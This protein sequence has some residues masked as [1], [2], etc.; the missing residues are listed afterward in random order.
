M[1][2]NQVI[3][4]INC[5]ADVI[6]AHLTDPK[7][8]ANFDSIVDK[9][10][11]LSQTPAA[12]GS[13]FTMDI[14]DGEH[15]TPVTFRVTRFDPHRFFAYESVSGTE[16]SIVVRYFLTTEGEKTELTFNQQID[17]GNAIDSA[18]AEAIRQETQQRIERDF[19]K[20]K[21]ALENIA[22]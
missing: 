5:P 19:Q 21:Q 3:V 10:N 16:L 17:P 12:V 18:R 15:R 22:S 4:T 7:N 14:R 11:I 6:F 2:E 9:T 13:E 8:F 1:I 20:L